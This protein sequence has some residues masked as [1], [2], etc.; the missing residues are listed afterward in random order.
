MSQEEANKLNTYEILF[1]LNRSV[2][3]MQSTLKSIELTQNALLKNMGEYDSRI[4]QIKKEHETLTLNFA[5]FQTKIETQAKTKGTIF[6]VISGA[7]V[8]IFVG[9]ITHYLKR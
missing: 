1:T 6:G 8:S 7:V 4:E 3:E 9:I 2:G 5:T